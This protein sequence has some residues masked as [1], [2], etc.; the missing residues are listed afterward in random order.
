MKYGPNLQT[1]HMREPEERGESTT[2]KPFLIESRRD[3]LGETSGLDVTLLT[4]F[5]QIHLE[6]ELLPAVWGN[7]TVNKAKKIQITLHHKLQR[8]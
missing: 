6:L 3:Q 1:A 5:V 2:A 4:Q 7:P 8:G